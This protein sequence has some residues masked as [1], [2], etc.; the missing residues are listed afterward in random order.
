MFSNMVSEPFLISA[1]FVDQDREAEFPHLHFLS[2]PYISS[3]LKMKK[4]CI[5][6]NICKLKFYVLKCKWINFATQI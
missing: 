3:D 5:L 4:T 2:F 6:E 1:L